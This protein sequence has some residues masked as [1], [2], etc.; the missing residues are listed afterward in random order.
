METN[1]I[2]GIVVGVLLVSMAVIAKIKD[3]RDN[4]KEDKKNKRF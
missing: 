2:I 4:K 3:I 1:V